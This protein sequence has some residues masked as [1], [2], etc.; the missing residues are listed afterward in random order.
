MLTFQELRD[1]RSWNKAGTSMVSFHI[2]P[3]YNL[4]KL[5]DKVIGEMASANN[6][7]SS[8]NRH[9]VISALKKIQEFLKD[10]KGSPSAGMAIFA[11]QDI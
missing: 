8:L 1:Y 3:S 6:I 10:L 4:D 2:P 5:K 11:E 9:S 7:K